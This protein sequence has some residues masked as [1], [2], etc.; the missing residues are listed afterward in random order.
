MIQPKMPNGVESISPVGP[1]AGGGAAGTRTM[2]RRRIRPLAQSWASF[3]IAS[4]SLWAI[5]PGLLDLS[6]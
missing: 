4:W 3:H 2:T 6:Q 5:L 1:E